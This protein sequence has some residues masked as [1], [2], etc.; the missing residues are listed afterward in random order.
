MPKAKAMRLEPPPNTIM[1]RELKEE[2]RK[3]LISLPPTATKAKL[4]K[5][6]RDILKSTGILPS[7]EAA[8]LVVN[9]SAALEDSIK[10][11]QKTLAALLRQQLQPQLQ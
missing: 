3:A 11:L 2:L 9:T 10:L 4:W 1:V 7:G 5:L 8:G 6:Y